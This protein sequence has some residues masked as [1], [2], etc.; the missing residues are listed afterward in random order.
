MF[1]NQIHPKEIV[2][3]LKYKATI[4]TVILEMI[5]Q[6][7]ETMWLEVAIP[8]NLVKLK[9][10]LEVLKVSIQESSPRL[11]THMHRKAHVNPLLN[12]V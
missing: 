8:T 2:I 1:G 11:Q 10:I 12:P 9:L 3:V 7:G 4:K 5:R 6:N